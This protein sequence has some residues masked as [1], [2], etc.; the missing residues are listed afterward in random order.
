M[1]KLKQKIIKKRIKIIRIKN[2]GDLIEM[3]KENEEIEIK[4]LDKSV[5]KM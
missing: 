1:N 4:I 3:E 5:K 2:K